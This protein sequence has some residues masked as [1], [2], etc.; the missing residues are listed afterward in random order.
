MAKMVIIGFVI[1]SCLLLQMAPAE[2]ETQPNRQVNLE[3]IERDNL[4]SERHLAFKKEAKSYQPPLQASSS[5]SSNH[6][7]IQIEHHPG[8]ATSHA[9]INYV[10]PIPSGPAGI[11]YAK[12]PTGPGITYSKPFTAQYNAQYQPQ[13]PQKVPQVHEDHSTYTVPSRQSLIQPIIGGSAPAANHLLTP[14]PQYVY[15]QAQPQQVH[16]YANHNLAQ[17][18][19][20]ILP[21][22][23]QA[24]IMIPSSYYQPPHS[25]QQYAAYVNDQDNHGGNNNQAVQAYSHGETGNSSPSAA[26]APPSG[27]SAPLKTPGVVYAAVPS[28]TPAPPRPHHTPAAADAYSVSQ[29]A[30]PAIYFN[31]NHLAQPTSGVQYSYSPAKPSIQ[32]HHEVRSSYPSLAQPNNGILNYLGVQ[33]KAP[34]SLLDSY[35]PSALQFTPLKQYQYP[36]KPAV[37][38]QVYHH[39]YH[40]HPQHHYPPQT[41]QPH[42]F[43]QPSYPVP[44]HSTYPI[45]QPPQQLHFQQPQPTP[46]AI[47]HIPAASSLYNTIAYSVP[48]A[49]TQT[50]TQ[51][52]RSPALESVAGF[53]P[54]VPQRTKLQPAAG[55]VN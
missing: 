10:T 7:A 26:A 46:T 13:Y 32:I 25:A 39:P 17:S 45:Y 3:D 4:N 44:H 29:N 42:Q 41:Q 6:Y 27:A 11:T 2:P 36:T 53:K 8:G 20:H 14:Q 19:M 47:S 5:Q 15:V 37:P 18:L 40:R 34:T 12:I 24:Y 28:S 49:H 52:K 33:H 35:V 31:H 54:S 21:Q 38:V 16:Q 48:L 23:Q 1:W 51:Y 43:Y 9:G 22:N 30:E 50:A 55:K